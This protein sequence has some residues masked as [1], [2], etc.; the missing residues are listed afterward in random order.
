MT[1]TPCTSLI[2]LLAVLTLSVSSA[3]VAGAADPLIEAVKRADTDRVRALLAQGVDVNARQGDGATALHWAAHR[4]DLETAVVLLGAGANANAANELGATPLWLASLSGSAAMVE[5]LLE[6]GAH[7]NATLSSGETPLMSAARAG[8]A[9]AVS[10]LLAHSADVNA[11]GAR[12]QTALMWAVAQQHADVARTLIAHGANVHAR[13]DVWHQLEN[14]AGNTNASGDFEMAHGG[15]TPLLFAARQGDIE[16]AR[17]LLTAGADVNDT[18]AAGTSVLVQAVHSGHGALAAYLL[19]AGADPNAADAGY[20]ALHAAVLRADLETVRT[21][22]AH[23]AEPNAL[24]LHGTPG[25]RFSAD[26]SL[27]SQYIGANAFWLAAKFADDVDIMRAL[28]DAGADPR[29]TPEDGTTAVKAAVGLPTGI[30]NRRARTGIPP[31]DPGLDERLSLEAARL[32]VELG[33]DVNAA[34]HRGDT[35][36]HDAAR[37]GYNSIIQLLADHGA[38]VNVQNTREQTPLS[39]AEARQ[40]LTGNYNDNDHTSTADLL[41]RLGAQDEPDH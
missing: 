5:R 17:V 22:L 15:S 31:R 26:Y 40:P 7:P 29:V 10:L 16:I 25:R 2:P 3:A 20:T 9:E 37:L 6:A 14:T 18:A 23:G 28:A 4:N 33:V 27:R 24:V 38:D 36:L 39:L 13:S 34:N 35:P 1:H 30:E 8:N 41:R 19:D 32:A 12:G 21:L 11:T